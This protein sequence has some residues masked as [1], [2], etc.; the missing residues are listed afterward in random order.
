[1]TEIIIRDIENMPLKPS[2]SPFNNLKVN[3]TSPTQRVII[4]EF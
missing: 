3:F 4:S 2:P 1:M